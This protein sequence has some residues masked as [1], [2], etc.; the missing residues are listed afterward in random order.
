MIIKRPYSLFPLPEDYETLTAEGQKQARMAVLQNHSTPYN[1]VLAWDFF[2]NLYLRQTQEAVFYKKGFVES[3]PF[4]SDMIF[5]IGKYDRNIYACPRGSAKST[6]I[7]ELTLLLSLTRPFYEIMLGLATDR[8]VEDRFDKLMFQFEHN[9]FLLQD[10]GEMKIKRGHGLWNH[11]QLSL[12]NGSI[13]KGLSVMGK[14]RGGRPNLFGL[15]DIENDPDSDSETSRQ[16]VVARFEMILFRQIIPM[17][18]AGSSI[19]W[20]GTLIDRKSFLY[21]ATM[22]DDSRFDFWNRKVLRA[23][24]TDESDSSKVHLLWP[25]KWPKTVLDRRRSEIGEAAFQAEYINEPISPSER[26]FE[27]DAK[28]NEYSVDGE[29]NWNNPLSYTGKVHWIDRIDTP[30]G[31]VFKEQERPYDELVKPM[32][33][34]LLF[35]YASGLTTYNDYSCIA[36]VGFDTTLTMW[37]LY[38]WL[39]RA[40]DDAL[41]RQIYEV[42]LAWKPRAVCIE[43]V[44]MQKSFAEAVREYAVEQVSKTEQQWTPRIFP[45]TYPSRESKAQRI[46]SALGWRFTTGKIKYP[47]HLAHEWPYCELYAETADFTMDLALLVHDDAIDTLAMTKYV[48]KIRGGQIRRELKRS[49]LLDRIIKGTP[50]VPGLPVLSGI[51]S[52]E[53]TDE[54]TNILSQQAR[55]RLTE[56]RDRKLRRRRPNVRF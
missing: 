39:G 20:V 42:G 31:R 43:A 35:D 33:R 24:A 22:G 49:G 5:D 11:H 17:L 38:L 13:I 34:L 56:T 10:F 1:L 52:A 29:F 32:S 48:L 18:E 46:S 25:A 23:I 3:P 45:V 8:L 27:V 44:G 41:M 16:T 30:T 14:K 53:V 7:L 15:D 54:M 26:N 40:R 2:R 47:A 19:I 9:E 28:K 21:R 6:L 37:V 51:S 4:H 50:V 36:V 55:K 12:T